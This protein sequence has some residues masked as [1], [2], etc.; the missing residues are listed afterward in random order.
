MSSSTSNG[1]GKRALSTSRAASY[2]PATRGREAGSTEPLSVDP[3]VPNAAR[4]YNVLL[5]GD[6]NFPADVQA[7]KESSEAFPGGFAAVQSSVRLNRAFIERSVRYLVH[8]AGVRQF[9]DLGTGVPDE[10]NVHAVAQREAPD[11]RVVSNDYDPVVLAHAHE[12]MRTT[13]EGDASFI[14]GDFRE[15]SQIM[16][17]S[18]DV[19]DFD[20]PVALMMVS[21]LHLVGDDEDPYGL[22]EAYKEALPAGSWLAMTELT[23]DMMDWSESAQQFD[24][25]LVEPVRPRTREEFARFF[26]GLEIVDPGIVPVNEW[27]PDGPMEGQAV[28]YAA[29]ARKP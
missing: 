20:R 3:N 16:A 11:S 13:P 5:G 17:T 27:R 2:R 18:A 22:V 10:T 26:D 23:H 28:H 25:N 9:L 24:E 8:E 4:V 7:A 19:L 21:L 14:L 1:P 6:A 29:V 12:V 15:A